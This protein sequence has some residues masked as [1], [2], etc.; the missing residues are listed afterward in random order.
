MW[1]CYAVMID[2]DLANMSS[3]TV[4]AFELIRILPSDYEH[5]HSVSYY[6]TT[7]GAWYGGRAMLTAA[8]III[9]LH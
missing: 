8:N 7:L 4:Q 6:C 5:I 9:V 2:C 3:G 1:H